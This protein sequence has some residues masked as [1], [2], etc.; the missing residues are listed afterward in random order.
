ML[1]PSPPYTDEGHAGAPFG[2]KVDLTNCD[3]EPIHI[4]GSIQPHGAM[5]VVS[6]DRFT[7]LYASD[8]LPEITGY[9]GPFAP[10]M[11]LGEILGDG[12]AHDI[13]NAAAKAGGGQIAGVELGMRLAH[14][15]HPLDVIVHQ[16]KNRVFIELEPAIDGGQSAKDALD[17]TQGLI[18]RIAMETDVE[19]LARSTAK[20]VRAMLGY[21]RVMVYQFLHNGAGKVIAEAKR[22]DLQSFMGQHF[23][24]SDI[25]YQAR[26]LYELNAIRMIGDAAYRP[27]PL[28]PALRAGE[29]PVDM[30]FAQLRSVS[31]IHCEYLQNMGVGAS[32]SI[33]IIIDGALW[34]LISC[35][36]DAPRMVPIPL[37]IGAELFGQYVSLQISVAE[38]RAQIVA[39][40]LAR[41]RLDRILS[42]LSMDETLAQGLRAHLKDFGTLLDCQGVGLWM[43][44]SWTACGA[45]PGEAEALALVRHLAGEGQH[46]AQTGISAR[47]GLWSTADLGRQ[48]GLPGFG[49][50]VAGV[51]AIPLTSTPR[52]YLML[53]RSEEAH[54]VEWAGEPVKR[55]VTTPQGDRLTPRGS[56]ETWRED[57]RGQSRPWSES[58]LVIGEAVRTYLRDVF[59][60]QTEA[61]AEERG[62]MEHRRRVLNDELNHRVKNIITLVK[63]IALQ[64]GA[65]AQSVADYS[66]SLEGRLRALAFAHDQS[67]S[68]TV[69]GDLETLIEAEA[70]LHRFGSAPN[71]V[72]ARGPRIGLNDRAFGALALVVHELMTNAAK[73]GALSTPQGQLDITWTLGEQGDCCIDWSESGGPVVTQ[74][75]RNGFGSRLI[76]TTLVYDLGGRADMDYAATGLRARL[77][78][79]G[80]HLA[81][82][83]NGPPRQLPTAVVPDR[84][85]ADMAVLLVED[86]SLIALDTEAMLRQLGARDVRLSPDA[87]H[88]ILTLG[89]FRPDVAVLDFN[90]GEGTSE[91]VAQHL[92]AIGV[93][94]VIATGYGDTVMIPQRLQTV[95]M[96]RKPASLASLAMRIEEARHGL[97]SSSA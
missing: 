10:G 34:G 14:A 29:Q 82:G 16:Y 77:V 86:Q 92:A 83:E 21:D 61:S 4:P 32:L 42:G 22:H 94:F 67:L 23:P 74:P 95:P 76:Q 58:D 46:H 50:D 35:H 9:T 52:D 79:P 96:V 11:A 73:Y 93:P 54:Q 97:Q 41:E 43:D 40:G 69:G 48:T 28:V 51:L 44:D 71:R 37:R 26:R 66:A 91:Q 31:P 39:S 84:P 45:A 13:R 49:T 57:V 2:G 12:P 6:A 90:L 87:T 80:R 7:A 33:S 18:R 27:V 24:A 89:A 88:A 19:S 59:L 5:L 75:T 36:H 63:S 60:K 72:V 85:L 70:G 64:T 38:R 30:S 62:Q 1:P 8:N 53:F 47:L 78:V 81:P 65:H 56:F 15:E 20:L 55:K 25:P 17:L 3:R 68:A